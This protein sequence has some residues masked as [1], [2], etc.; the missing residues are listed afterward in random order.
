VSDDIRPCTQGRAHTILTRR[1]LERLDPLADRLVA[2][3][4]MERVGLLLEFWYFFRHRKAW[5]ML[6][7]VVALL[8]IAA[9][10]VLGEASALAPFIYPLF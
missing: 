5:W 8:L 3:D 7:L 4:W 9:L 1:R 2:Y 10:T 6:P